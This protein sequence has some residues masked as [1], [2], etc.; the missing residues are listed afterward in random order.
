[1]MRSLIANPAFAFVNSQLEPSAGHDLQRN[2][3]D[4]AAV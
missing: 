4:K 1:M 3:I 2:P